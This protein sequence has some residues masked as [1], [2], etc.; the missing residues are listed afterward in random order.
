M[1][2]VS[3]IDPPLF[4]SIFMLSVSTDIF[5]SLLSTTLLTASTDIAA[6]WSL[7]FSAALPVIAVIAIFISLSLSSGV[8][9]SA[10]LSRISRLL[11][12]ANLYPL[13]MTV[14]WISWSRR[15]SAFFSSSPAIIAAVVVPS[16][17]SSSCVFATSTSIFAAGCSICISSRIVTP[18]FVIT[19]SPKESTS[20]LSMPFGPSVDLT[21]SATDLAAA[22][23]ACCAPLPEVLNM[24]SGKTNIG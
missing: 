5:P 22:M 2:S 18:S 9:L 19:M 15:F 16:P 11:S 12:F 17:T 4:F 13:V 14:G 8:I 21:A 24:P 3:S 10:M 1:S 23:F 7:A 6:R 20:I